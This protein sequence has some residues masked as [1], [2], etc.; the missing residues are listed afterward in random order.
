MSINAWGHGH[1]WPQ[2]HWLTPTDSLNDNYLG[3]F[4]T[5]AI[6]IHPNR[7]VLYCKTQRNK[8]KKEGKESGE[9]HTWL[10]K[11]QGCLREG[12]GKTE[13]CLF[14]AALMETQY[15]F[16]CSRYTL[17]SIFNAPSRSSSWR[18]AALNSETN[19]PRLFCAL[20]T[21]SSGFLLT[22]ESRAIS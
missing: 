21:H 16:I 9:Q 2:T 3:Y 1:P 12:E 11:G 13:K 8:G 18:C 5:D 19:P 6:L 15:S 10:I 20:L 4:A 17:V 22:A 14:M 7:D